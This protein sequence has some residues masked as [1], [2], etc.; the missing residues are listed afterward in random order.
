[1]RRRVAGAILEKVVIM[2][3]QYDFSRARKNPYASLL[4]KQVTIRLD[5]GTV[6]YFKQLA[7]DAGIPY[8]TLINLYLRDC[9]ASGRKLSM[10]WREVS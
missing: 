9:A 8:Q 7:A 3:K 4:K 6:K 2:R 5:E 10:Q 1:M